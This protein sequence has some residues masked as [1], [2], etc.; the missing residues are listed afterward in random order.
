ME[1]SPSVNSLTRL[2]HAVPNSFPNRPIE[3]ICW[4][5]GDGTDSCI[6]NTSTAPPALTISH[7][8]PAPGVYRTCVKV[9]F[10]GGCIAEACKE[11][12]IRS[13]SHMC[14]GYMT[15]SMISPH[16]FKFKGFAIHNPND[17]VMSFR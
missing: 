16:T 1:V 10:Q 14:G 2:L 7:T 12:V 11:I 5:F 8:Y 3:K 4:Y 9:Y 15:D 6:M 13:N 17:P